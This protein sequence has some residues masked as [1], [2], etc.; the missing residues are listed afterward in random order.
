MVNGDEKYTLK[1]FLMW[2]IFKVFI[3]F[4][5]ILLLFY[6]LVFWPRGMWDRSSPTRHR[7]CTPCIGRQSLNHWTPRDVPS[8]MK[9]KQRWWILQVGEM[10]CREKWDII[11]N[12]FTAGKGPGK[13]RLWLVTVN[14]YLSFRLITETM[15][16][17]ERW[18]E[19]EVFSGH[20]V[21]VEEAVMWSM[22]R[23][24]QQMR[25]SKKDP[26][27]PAATLLYILGQMSLGKWFHDSYWRWMLIPTPPTPIPCVSTEVKGTSTSQE[28][29][30]SAFP[31]TSPWKGVIYLIFMFG[32]SY[33]A[34]PSHHLPSLK[35]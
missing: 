24:Y 9:I 25:K 17:D 20:L 21:G 28:D 11:E 32:Q 2:T 29:T 26:T 7:T 19:Q 33:W 27:L 5:T 30:V 6:V 8:G 10:G 3:E 35:S 23:R 34:C 22:G 4:V 1:I 15:C 12:K 18:L 16:V 14:E 13:T 31:V